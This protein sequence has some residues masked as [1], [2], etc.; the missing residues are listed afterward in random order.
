MTRA[1]A[2]EVSTQVVVVGAGPVGLMLACELR[3]AHV[4][5]V[6]VERLA[7]PMT[8]SRASQ[9]TTLTAE[10]LHERGLDQLLEEAVHE[11]RAH[12]AGLSFDVSGL[13]SDYAGHW[14]VPQF[15]TEG[16]LGLRAERLGASLLRAHELTGIRASEDHVVC[17]VRGP[18]ED[19]RIRAQYLAGC[20]GAHSMVRRLCGFT[21]SATSA[22]KELLRADVTGIDIPDRRFESFE[23]GFAVASTRDGVTRVMVHAFGQGVTER[24][25]PPGFPEVAALWGRVAG[26]D[27]S[28]GHAIWVDSFDN[29]RGQV[30]VYRRGRVLLAGDAAHWHMPIGGQS[31]NVGLQDA[32][33]LGWKLAGSVNGWASPRLLDS[34]HGERH[35]VARRAL[36]YVAAQEILL[37]GGGG[38]EPLRAVLS[39]LLGLERVSGHLARVVSGLD[40]RYGPGDSLLAGRRLPNVQLRDEYGPV[41][42]AGLLAHAEP[43][44]VRLRAPANDGAEAA[45]LPG[46]F[47]IRTVHAI[48]EE[49][50][51]LRG[52]NAMLVRP[53]G[54]IAWAGDDDEDLG[55]AIEQLFCAAPVPN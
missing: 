52:I 37:L 53:D 54:Y 11:P 25:A 9:L 13:D 47:R 35:P 44:I 33:N 10:I 38:V 28:G 51:S 23:D 15:R 4:P 12:F 7:S 19:L 21:S 39:E 24:R 30:D 48:T 31:L 22:T 3:R 45:A 50:D 8:E 20:D 16:I 1:A 2:R 40:D 6:I 18:A 46:G 36:S 34:Y 43:V 14:K 5:V 27:I 17:A 42:A 49:A 26:D 32:L 41:T 55:R 29:S